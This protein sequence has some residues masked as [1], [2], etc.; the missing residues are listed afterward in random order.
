VNAIV[1]V[2]ELVF[3]QEFVRELNKPPIVIERFAQPE[4][5]GMFAMGRFISPVGSTVKVGRRVRVNPMTGIQ[6]LTGFQDHFD[7]VLVAVILGAFAGVPM[8][9]EDIHLA[10]RTQPCIPTNPFYITLLAQERRAA[11]EIRSH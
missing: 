6:E 10:D 5:T 9:E 7:N 2:T 8:K 11:G 1:S 4:S 3:V